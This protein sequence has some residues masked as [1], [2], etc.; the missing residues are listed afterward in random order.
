MMALSGILRVPLFI[1]VEWV[2]ILFSTRILVINFQ[3]FLLS[4]KVLLPVRLAYH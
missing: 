3:I 1:D 2:Q 4:Q